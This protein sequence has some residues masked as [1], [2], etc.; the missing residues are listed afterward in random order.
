M[1]DNH[2]APITVIALHCS[3]AS[4]RQWQR[5]GEHLFPRARLIAPDLAGYGRN[6]SF[7]HGDHMTL[8]SEASPIVALIDDA[9]A[10]VHLVGHSY[11]GA[12]ALRAALER[13]NAV[14]SLTLYEPSAFGLLRDF[15]AA[16]ESAS[17]E[18]HR[19]IASIGE[20]MGKAKHAEA[21]RSFYEYWQGEGSWMGLTAEA[22]ASL[23]SRIAKVPADFD[24][25]MGDSMRLSHPR[26]LSMPTM[27]MAG[28]TS[29]LPSR[30][31]A[32]HVARVIPRGHLLEVPGAGHMAP[33]THREWV[34]SIISNNILNKAL[35]F[36]HALRD[37]A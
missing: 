32:A 11:A 20:L 12:V 24:A 27:V 21:M 34:A 29:P 4:G 17:L 33:L 16:G 22:R 19:L 1:Y 15:R 6:S 36:R 35:Q 8:A 18:I 23:I 26:R 7:A 5:L 31:V 28:E 37:A 9:E 25:I 3:G 13:P 30:L 2:S 14:A 10:Q